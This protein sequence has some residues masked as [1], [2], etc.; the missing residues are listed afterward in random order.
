LT[1]LL[2]RVPGA[3]DFAVE[4]VGSRRVRGADVPVL[5]LI[6]LAAE[7]EGV[8]AAQVRHDVADHGRLM[9]LAGGPAF[10]CRIR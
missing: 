6:Q 8:T 4:G 3:A 2:R 5:V 1:G 7:P 9:D 10:S